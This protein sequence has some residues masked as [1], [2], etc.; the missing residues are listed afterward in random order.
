M[1]I[2]QTIRNIYLLIS[3][4]V[5]LHGT[6]L[7]M[8]VDGQFYPNSLRYFTII[9]N[10]LAVAG[11]LLMLILQNKK[12]V[13]RP[14]IIS[15][16]MIGIFTTSLVYNFILVPISKADIVFSSYSNFIIHLFSAVLVL[17]EYLIFEKKGMFTLRHIL[18]ALAVP[19]VYYVVFLSIGSI[20]NF[21]PYF[22]MN[23]VQI[24][25]LYIFVWFGISIAFFSLLS[26]LV[27]LLDKKLGK[28]N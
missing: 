6:S 1:P 18:A 14:Y 26:L 13:L 5:V 21:Y 4:A 9:S 7:V 28:K 12:E 25:W 20:I 15:V 2:K 3:S 24:G 17:A 8:I 16:M 19:A 22:F 10:L 11:F 27:L 23:P